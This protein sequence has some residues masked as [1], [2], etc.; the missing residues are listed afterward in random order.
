MSLLAWNCRGV[1]NPATVQVLVD[2]IHD[3]RPKI[4]FLI[5]T[6]I[7]KNKFQPIK[8]KLGF[9]GLFTVDNRGH[10]GGLALLWKDDTEVTITGFSRNHIDATVSL[11]GANKWRFTGFYG[12]PKRSRRHQSWKLLKHL[13]NLSSLP[14]PLMGDF[15]DLLSQS[16]KRGK[17]PHP[18]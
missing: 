1:G 8:M 13:A 12:H 4:V 3:K 9:N 5:E 15:N 6:L 16:E 18:K 10:S 2:L 11:E 14:W 17:T 7:D